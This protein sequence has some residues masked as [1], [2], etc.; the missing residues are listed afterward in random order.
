V[1][2]PGVVIAVVGG[3]DHRRVGAG[4]RVG[5]DVRQR[6]VRLHAGGAGVAVDGRE[7]Q[8]VEAQVVIVGV[9]QPQAVDG[10]GEVDPGWLAGGEER[11][12][13]RRTG[14]R[15]RAGRRVEQQHPV[16]ARQR[17]D[18]PR[19]GPLVDGLHDLAGQEA[20]DRARVAGA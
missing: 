5:R 1:G 13:E 9:D 3:R 12:L 11:G 18:L 6:G 19:R 15:Q 17:E 8:R 2:S 7:Q 14:L 10:G 16:D 20:D 4:V